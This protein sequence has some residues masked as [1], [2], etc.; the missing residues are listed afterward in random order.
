MSVTSDEALVVGP[1]VKTTPKA[2]R[3]QE[4]RRRIVE[5]ARRHFAEHGLRGCR[6]EDIATEVGITRGGILR[7][8]A[9]KDE[10]L[11]EVHKTAAMSMASYLDAPKDVLEQGFAAT[12]RFWLVGLAHC[13]RED[14]SLEAHR[15]ILLGLHSTEL[16]LQEQISRFWLSEDPEGTLEFVEFGQR[17][18]EVRAD[19]DPH[20]VA[21]VIDW[22]SDGL[23]SSVMAR[24]LDRVGLFRARGRGPDDLESVV[25]TI[26][27]MLR[28]TILV[29]SL[30]QQDA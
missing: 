8:F 21:A 25:D 28:G 12:L 17:R 5:V 2:V 11:I 20:V 4:T 3:G 14:H 23:S 27:E 16:D 9:S 7:H 22:I 10:L 1:D 18:G 24:E 30:A 13:L 26:I 29:R 6:L 15:L 19:L